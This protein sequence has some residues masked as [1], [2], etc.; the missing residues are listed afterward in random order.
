MNHVDVAEAKA[1][2]ERFIAKCDD[3]LN[4]LVQTYQR[5]HKT[6]EYVYVPKK[7]DGTQYPNIRAAAVKRS[8]LDLT[9]ALAKMRKR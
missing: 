1:E 7:W 8:S 2:A 6:G 9:R 3:L 4:T 5:D